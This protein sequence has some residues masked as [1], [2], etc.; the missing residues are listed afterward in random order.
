[1]TLILTAPQRLAIMAKDS[2]TRF[3]FATD[4]FVATLDDSQRPAAL[5]LVGSGDYPPVASQV[6]KPTEIYTI[7]IHGK[8]FGQGAVTDA[9]A[10]TENRSLTASVITYFIKRSQLQFSNTRTLE[11]ADLPALAGV[12]S[13]RL[14]RDVLV[15]LEK[16]NESPFWG[17]VITVTIVTIEQALEVLV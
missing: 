5:I 15:P 10:E 16:G 3:V 14:R 13:F 11:A 1:M 2:D 6:E 9:E 7:E 4:K 8:K 17:C 12:E